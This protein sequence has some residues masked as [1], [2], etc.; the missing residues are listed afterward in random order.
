MG[1]TET[2]GR[3]GISSIAGRTS[4]VACRPNV[5]EIPRT[6]GEIYQ[7]V[8]TWENGKSSFVKTLLQHQW[9]ERRKVRTRALEKVT[10]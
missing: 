9:S 3:S 6:F 5:A 2:G 1:L 7:R 10:F 8:D 4:S